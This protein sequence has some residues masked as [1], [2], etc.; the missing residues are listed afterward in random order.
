MT[1]FAM[2]PAL[3][4]R[5]DIHKSCK[6]IETLLNV[7]NEYCEAASAVV[8]LQKKLAKALRE[9]ASL[10]VTTD[11]AANAMNASANIF[12]ALSDIDSKFSKVA[13][14]EYDSVSSEVKK[15]FKKLAKEEKAHD[16]RMA[17]ANARIKQA[18]QAYEKKSKK[19]AIDAGEEHARY[20]NLIS[21]L[22]PEVSQEK[23]NHTRTVTQKHTTTTYSVAACLSRLADTEW[24]RS[25]ECVRRFSPTVGPLG[26]WRSLCEGG[27]TGQVPPNLPDLDGANNQQNQPADIESTEREPAGLKTI[28]EEPRQPLQNQQFPESPLSSNGDLS[29]VSDV[30]EPMSRPTIQSLRDLPSSATTSTQ[31]SPE[32]KFKTPKV[33]EEKANNEQPNN[34]EVQRPIPTSSKPYNR[35]GHEQD[36]P[37]FGTLNRDLDMP[38]NSK[39]ADN[40]KYQRPLERADTGASSGSIV[41]AMRNRYSNTSGSMSPP[42]RDVPRLPLSVNDLA[43]RYQP[44]DATLSPRTRTGSPPVTRQQSLPLL[45]TAARQTQ[46]TYNSRVPV[47]PGPSPESDRKWQQRNEDPNVVER[48]TKEQELRARERELEMRARELDRER[49]SQTHLGLPPSPGTHAFPSSPQRSPKLADRSQLPNPPQ[50]DPQYESRN[51]DRYPSNNGH[52]SNTNSTSNS[53]HASYCGCESCSVSKYKNSGPSSPVQQYRQQ[54]P[55]ETSPQLQSQRSEKSSKLGVGW[56]RR[57][58]MPVGNAFSGSDSKRHQSNNS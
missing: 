50:S 30:E 34:Q 33:P 27:W 14:K 10:K 36:T 42:A 35:D 19:K 5:T 6:S 2:A 38:A 58:S 45:D 15:W 11:I 43:S 28:G 44:T 7:L 22:G 47:Q 23:Y 32:T 40:S 48:N 20:I 56:M 3:A 29:G 49:A 54:S 57:L 39:M 55:Q 24:Q 52:S 46:E 53:A 4:E 21:T 9:T 51:R 26:Q 18:G 13:D 16:E 41:A 31:P 12:E 25:C 37:E 1:S 8:S 17:N